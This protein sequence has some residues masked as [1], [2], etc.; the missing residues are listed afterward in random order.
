MDV[1]LL[2]TQWDAVLSNPVPTLIFIGLAAAAAWWFKSTVDKGQIEALKGQIEALRAKHDVLEARLD[3]NKAQ[4]E[5]EK[6][7]ETDEKGNVK[8]PDTT[9][10]T[11]ETPPIENASTEPHHQF[12]W[13]LRLRYAYGEDG[14]DCLSKATE[15]YN[16]LKVTPGP[17]SSQMIEAEYLVSLFKCGDASALSKL[18]A[19]SGPRA[20]AFYANV[21]LGDYYHSI[22]ENDAALKCLEY[23]FEHPPDSEHKFY[24][25]LTLA[26]FMAETGRVN[27]AIS[28]L[29][30][31]RVNFPSET[32][33]A[34]IWETLGKIYGTRQDNTWRKLLCF[35]QSL[36]LNPNN[37]RL[38]FSLA[39]S[40]GDTTYAKAMAAH[41]YEILRHQTPRDTTVANNLSVIYDQLGAVTKKISLLRSA[42]RS[43]KD[44]AYVAANLATAYAKAGFLA[45]ARECLKD[46]SI[47]DQQE[48]IVRTAYDTINSQNESDTKTGNKLVQLSNMENA[49]IHGKAL[50]QLNE[51]DDGLLSKFL[52]RWQLEE[53]SDFAVHLILVIALQG[54]A[55]AGTIST[56]NAYYEHADYNVTTHYEPG[57]LVLNAQLNEASLKDRPEVHRRAVNALTAGFGSLGLSGPGGIGGGLATPSLMERVFNRPDAQLKLV[58]VPGESD[59]LHG[60]KATSRTATNG[61][62]EESQMMLNAKEVHLTR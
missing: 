46:I 3:S 16:K 49:F 25:A 52:G 61:D 4:P 38:R 32:D 36:A 62:K 2:K 7:L 22:G 23:R 5:A 6:A 17:M 19:Q 58:L 48:G 51:T 13:L 42:R 30:T 40:Y 33:Q 29:N 45:D 14:D 53:S 27:D 44:D 39:Y 55:V 34:A 60:I 12:D 50:N 56:E 35:E 9:P 28:F 10:S 18:Q 31:Q 59:S 8:P 20:E 54:G 24:S 41:H 26:E 21:A 11:P 37:T 1:S 15:Y 43:G 47:D 57:L